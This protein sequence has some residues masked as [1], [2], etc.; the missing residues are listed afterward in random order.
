MRSSCFI[1]SDSGGIQEEAPTLGK[2][3]LVTRDTTERPEGIQAGTSVLVGTK[4]E[5]ILEES[6]LL[7]HQPDELQRR[8][9][10]ANPY[11]DGTASQSIRRILESHFAERGANRC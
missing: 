6:R 10:I 9:R 3:V 8:G 11:G 5:T 4:V 1:I 2:P 7:L